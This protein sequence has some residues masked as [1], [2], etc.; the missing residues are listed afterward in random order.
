MRGHLPKLDDRLSTIAEMVRDGARCADIGTDHGYLIAWLAASGKIPSGYA[1]DI[2]KGPLERAAFSL[3]EYEVTDRIKPILCDGLSGLSAGMV[4]DIIIAGMGG[5]LIWEII[6]V[7]SWTRDGHLRFL[8]QPM[9]KPERL[10]Q[11]LYENGFEIIQEKAVVSG[12]FPYTVMQVAYTGGCHSIDLPFAYGGLVLD[13]VDEASRAYIAKAARLV[14]EKVEGM[15][16][17]AKEEDRLATY[18][19]LLRRLEGERET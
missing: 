13:S 15:S 8:L 2:N 6:A 10:R 17:A 5:D 14:R 7:Q 16:K 18:C 1:C 19:A 3:S 11:R 4:D 9:T 12:D